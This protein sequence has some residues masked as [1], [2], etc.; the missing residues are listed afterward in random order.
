MFGSIGRVID[1]PVISQGSGKLEI[2]VEIH[3]GTADAVF[4]IELDPSLAAQNGRVQID[5]TYAFESGEQER[6]YTYTDNTT[7]FRFNDI[8]AD[9]AILSASYLSADIRSK[10]APIE[11]HK[12]ILE[13][14]K[15]NHFT[16]TFNPPTQ[17]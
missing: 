10:L 14:G 11:A 5:L 16:L 1:I 12:V 15:E 2:D 4:H 17:K 6:I 8:Q 3:E 9:T 13:E 7:E